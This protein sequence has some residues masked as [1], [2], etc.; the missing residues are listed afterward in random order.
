M[1]L[2]LETLELGRHQRET[3]TPR[4]VTS[5]L[6]PIFL[7]LFFMMFL[8]ESILALARCFVVIYPVLDAPLSN[9]YARETGMTLY[10]V[11]ITWNAGSGV[12]GLCGSCFVQ[13]LN[14]SR[15]ILLRACVLHELASMKHTPREVRLSRT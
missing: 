11:S 4:S 10:V 6:N 2:V 14:D 5:L 15:L 3:A 7:Y 12:C 9:M 1:Y 8:T 13:V